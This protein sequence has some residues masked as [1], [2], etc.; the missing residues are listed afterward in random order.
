MV[1]R[2]DAGTFV[3]PVTETDDDERAAGAW[4]D[5]DN[6]GD[7]DLYLAMVT[8]TNRL[9]RN[10]GAGV[11]TSVTGSTPLGLAGDSRDA[12]WVDV[13]NDGDLDLFV[14]RSASANVLF[15]NGGAA[16]FVSLGSSALDGGGVRRATAW[17]D[18][19]G[20]GDLDA[21]VAGDS[22]AGRLIRND[23]PPG[24][25]HWL[26]VDLVGM[27]SNRSG[28]GARLHLKSGGVWQ[29]RDVSGGTGFS[30]ESPTSEFGLGASTLVDSLVVRWRT[31]AVQV[32]TGI[33]ADQR[34]TVTESGTT[35]VPEV[36]A[37]LGTTLWP[38]APNPSPA[39]VAVR[40]LLPREERVR[41]EVVDVTGR[42]VRLLAEGRLPAGQHARSWDGADAVGQSGPAGLYWV[43]LT[44]GSLHRSRRLVRLR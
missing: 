2:N 32:L 34:V 26:H 1:L 10:D 13:D 43:R 30:Q 31:N 23:L 19:D 21:Y 3:Y 35:G 41:L 9:L 39:S 37:G 17:A 24:Q 14:V 11:F 8:G 20:D 27:H 18:Y 42:L 7:P 36:R 12:A 25:A 22:T 28:I 5:Y 15:R 40:F 16:G 29:M 4:G 44:A 6:D 38:P 33:A